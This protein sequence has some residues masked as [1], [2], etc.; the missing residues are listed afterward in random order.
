MLPVNPLAS[1]AET[2]IGRMGRRRPWLIEHRSAK[3][4]APFFIADAKHPFIGTW[5]VVLYPKG[6][7]M[8]L[9]CLA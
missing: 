2:V 8:R 7:P 4:R 6:R 3:E 9:P 5:G 1:W